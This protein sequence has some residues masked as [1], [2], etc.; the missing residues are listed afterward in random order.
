MKEYSEIIKLTSGKPIRIEVEVK[1]RTLL[2]RVFLKIGLKK[3]VVKLW[4]KPITLNQMYQYSSCIS[5]LNE[6]IGYDTLKDI[7][8]IYNVVSSKYKKQ[9]F[10][11]I[12]TVVSVGEFGGKNRTTRILDKIT[13]LELFEIVKV[14]EKEMNLDFFLTSINS[15]MS[16][17]LPENSIP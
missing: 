8:S 13:V 1:P 7:D 3:P 5:D 12:S 9:F 4:I 2:D 15:L 6:A 16:L 11:A 17:A 10:R 14:I